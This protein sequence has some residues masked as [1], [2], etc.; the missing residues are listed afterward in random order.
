M[1]P[2]KLA[3][4]VDVGFHI[5]YATAAGAPDSWLNRERG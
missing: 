2:G 4:G 5:A 1:A 3:A